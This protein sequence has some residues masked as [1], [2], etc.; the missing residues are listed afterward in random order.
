MNAR[1]QLRRL[2][3]DVDTAATR[4]QRSLAYA[5]AR[6]EMIANEP[7]IGRKTF[8]LLAFLLTL[9][10]SSYFVVDLMGYSRLPY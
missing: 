6:H 5:R 10:G 4:A 7:M 2:M 3:A 8:L 9:A 1:S